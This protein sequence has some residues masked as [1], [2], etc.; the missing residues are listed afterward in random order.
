MDRPNIIAG[1]WKMYKTADEAAAFVKELAPVVAEA[2]SQVYLAVP[3]TLIRPAAD[4]AEGS[5][6]IIGA[7]NMN[8]AE[9]GAF[10]GEIAARMLLDAGARFVVLGHSERRRL[11]GESS[12]FVNKKVKRALKDGLCPILC[13][14]ETDE[15]REGGSMQQVLE[16]QMKESLEGVAKEQLPGVVLAYEPVWAIGTGK[17]ASPEQAQ[18]AH[19]HCRKILEEIGGSGAAESVSILYGGSVSPE[20]AVAFMESRDID[21]LLV[22]GASLS[23]EKFSKII[24]RKGS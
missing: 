4:A 21:G 24:K 18:E 5:R 22:G 6:I 13:V 1:N 14:G 7:Q 3:Y 2:A 15:E 19:R 11:F 23:V 8:D 9:E 20:N 10:T 17:S 16:R 12:A